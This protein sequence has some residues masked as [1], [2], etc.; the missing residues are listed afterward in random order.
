MPKLQL[1]PPL[2]ALMVKCVWLDLPS[3]DHIQAFELE[4][5]CLCLAACLAVEGVGDCG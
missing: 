1:P 2:D 4:Q 5:N 3:V